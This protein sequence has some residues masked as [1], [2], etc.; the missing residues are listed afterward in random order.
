MAKV[1]LSSF[2]RGVSGSTSNAVYRLTKFGTELAD[3]PISN[4]P[5]TPSQSAVRGAFSKVTK[6]WK[7]LSATQAAA[8][9]AYAANITETEQISGTKVKRTGFNWFVALGAR[10]LWIN[11]SAT[12]APVTP[13]AN[14]FV[15]DALKITATAVAGGIKFSAPAANSA[16]TTTALQV[17]KLTSGNGKSGKAYTTKAHFQFKTGGLES[18]V[19]LAPGTYSVAIQFVELATGQETVRTVIGKVGPV[20]FAVQN[21]PAQKKAA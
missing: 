21:A 10:Y 20:S 8:W 18:T 7:T 4:N 13:P 1:K 14:A 9:N 5:N 2:A 3:R 12:T 19:L 6:Q 15:G 16:G 11:D 17:Q